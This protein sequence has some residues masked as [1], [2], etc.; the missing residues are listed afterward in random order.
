VPKGSHLE[1]NSYLY[2]YNI[3]Q[4]EEMKTLWN[5]ADNAI[6]KDTKLYLYEN[7]YYD[8]DEETGDTIIT[9]EETENE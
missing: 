2:A 4:D 3:Y 5:F 7:I 1:I 6:N 9:R 8:I